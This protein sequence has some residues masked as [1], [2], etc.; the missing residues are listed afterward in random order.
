MILRRLNS[1]R[2]LNAG[3]WLPY[4]GIDKLTLKSGKNHRDTGFIMPL[5]F[6]KTQKHAHESIDNFLPI[7]NADPRLNKL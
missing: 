3:N 2:S 6:P 5:L 4:F 1:E 7:P